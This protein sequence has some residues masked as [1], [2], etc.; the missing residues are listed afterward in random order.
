MTA[1][2]RRWFR[3]SLRTLFVVMM[4][5][6]CWLGLQLNWIRQRH[7]ALATWKLLAAG[8]G[9]YDPISDGPID[10]KPPRMLWAFGEPGYE[11]IWRH[12]SPRQGSQLTDV[13][14][15]EVEEVTKLFP[16]AIVKWH[17]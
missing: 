7:N 8:M 6:G 2:K 13:E 14:Q 5:F 1:A 4:V 10:G 12:F 15:A 16:E 9:M 11:I 3:F 17:I